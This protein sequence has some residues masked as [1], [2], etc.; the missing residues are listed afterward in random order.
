PGNADGLR[1]H[2][3]DLSRPDS[4]SRSQ[5]VV[6]A[7]RLARHRPAMAS[8][9]APHSDPARNWLDLMGIDDPH[10]IDP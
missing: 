5:A 10:R 3:D 8:D 7:R 9:R 2:V 6:C 1:L 4:L